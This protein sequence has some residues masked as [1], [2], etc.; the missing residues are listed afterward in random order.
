MT[1]ENL[2][3]LSSRF[4]TDPAVFESDK[5]HVF[6]RTW[7]YVGHVSA[8]PEV[9]SFLTVR[10]AD[11]SLIIV[12]DESEIVRAFYNVC[13]YRAHRLVDGEGCKSRFVCPYHAWSY[14]LDGKLA[15]APKTEEVP[16]FD[17][18]RIALREVRLELFAGLMFINL[19]DDAQSMADVFVGLEQELLAAKPALSSMK[20]IFKDQITHQ[21]NWKVSVENFSECYHCPVAHRYVTSNLYSADRYRVTIED[22]VVRHFSER[23]SDRETHGD[24]YVWFLWPNLA[25]ELYPLHRCIS[26]RHFAPITPRTTVYTYLW[27]V[28]PDLPDDAVAEVAQL[29]E[30]YRG[31]NGAEDEAI[32]AAVQEGLESRSY[33][34]GQ[35]VI[36]PQ[37][38]A[39]SEHAVA[40]FQ[41][42]YAQALGV[43]DSS[44]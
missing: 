6:Y 43:G 21:S 36:P 29:G 33:D 7:Q 18:T 11:E 41:R 8:L 38:T 5:E 25:I 37:L 16:G 1:G 22:Y 24:L 4:Y 44:T 23:L 40:H 30:T 20:L 3:T 34:V 31:T 10:I 42:L 32:V 26:I 12:R 28:D 14:A 2:T 9:G 27:F 35:L 15:Q 17:K 13:R 19:D 39:Q